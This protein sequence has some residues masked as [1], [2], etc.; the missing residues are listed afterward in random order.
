MKLKFNLITIFAVGLSLLLA[1]CGQQPIKGSGKQITDNRSAASFNKI[2]LLGDFEVVAT[3]GGQ[4]PQVSVTADDN[5]VPF[6]Q[7]NVKGDT[8]TVMPAKNKN[9]LATSKP[10]ITVNAADLTKI[11]LDG[12]GMVNVVGLKADKVKVKLNGTG[13]ITLAGNV[14]AV[15]LRLMGTG[16]IN[17]KDLKA[18][19]A[20]IRLSGSGQVSA[21]ATKN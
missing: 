19:D 20:E 1:A 12:K 2:V 15:D 5:I 21:F 4:G 11:E 13:Q 9:L 14:Q 17:A 7:T 6:I 10:K 3:V 18:N 8:L 16:I